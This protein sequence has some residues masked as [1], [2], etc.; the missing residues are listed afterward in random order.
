MLLC[1]FSKKTQNK[2][3]IILEYILNLFSLNRRKSPAT[4]LKFP[5]GFVEELWTQNGGFIT[6]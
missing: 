6:Y 4:N 5:N 2:I 1:S 3:C